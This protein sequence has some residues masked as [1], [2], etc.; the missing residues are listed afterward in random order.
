LTIFVDSHCHLNLRPFEADLPAVLERAWHSGIDHILMPGI[1]LETSRAVVALSETDPRLYAAVGF[2]PNDA[3]AW[4]EDAALELAQLARH[5]RVLAI[6][7]IGLDFY[8]DRAPRDVQYRVLAAQLAL[9]AEVSKPVVIHARQSLPELWPILASWQASLAKSAPALSDR[10]GVLHSFDGDLE[11]ALA[12]LEAHFFLGIS[13]PVTF[14][15]APERQQLV[16]QLPLASLLLETDAPFLAPQPVRG[17]RNEP[18]NIPMIAEKIAELH[19]QPL[20]VV[21]KVTTQ[22]ADRLLG[23]RS[24]Y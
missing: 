2:H 9:A 19:S 11:T 13:G 5:P 10:P 12:A 14:H 3:L 7:E 1:D 6:G 15:N 24:E 16:S 4:N 17:Q 23:W 18:A 21:A 22:N 20:A 8:R